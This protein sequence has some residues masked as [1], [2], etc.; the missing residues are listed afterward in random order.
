MD[1]EQRKEFEVIKRDGSKA[2][3]VFVKPKNSVWYWN[4]LHSTSE[5]EAKRLGVRSLPLPDIELDKAYCLRDAL[6]L[7]AA[8]RGDEWVGQIV[9]DHLKC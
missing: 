3:F 6:D 8:K 2:T 9:A 5:E 1:K 7:I 4:L